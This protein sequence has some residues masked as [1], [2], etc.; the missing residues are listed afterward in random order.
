M[1]AKNSHFLN[2]G[3]FLKFFQLNSVKKDMSSNLC[4][5][6]L[7]LS[8][9]FVHFE[10]TCQRTKRTKLKTYL[11][12]PNLAQK[13]SKIGQNRENGSF[14]P[15]FSS[16]IITQMDEK[17]LTYSDIWSKK[18]TKYIEYKKKR[19]SEIPPFFHSG[20]KLL[21]VWGLPP[22]HTIISL[23]RIGARMGFQRF[24]VIWRVCYRSPKGRGGV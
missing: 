6:K 20:S 3:H 8:Y 24:R 22:L 23:L 19:K 9:F 16:P 15:T 14:W 17:C 5:P 2:F 10:V 12:L 21:I 11:F 7:F 4:A 18:Y 1:W 13:T